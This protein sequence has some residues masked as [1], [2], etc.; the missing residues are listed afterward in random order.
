MKMLKRFRFGARDY[1]S[2]AVGL[3]A[4][5]GIYVGLDGAHWSVPVIGGVFMTACI[6]MAML[7]NKALKRQAGE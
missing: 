1:V 4:G 7:Q 6:N 5:I 2:L 3:I